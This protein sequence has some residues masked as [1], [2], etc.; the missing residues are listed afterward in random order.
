MEATIHHLDLVTDL[1]DA[2]G[3]TAEGLHEVR[4][5]LDGLLGRQAPAEWPDE[6]Y[7]RVA[8]GRAEPTAEERALL[9]DRLPV[10]S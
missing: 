10:F 4:R 5:V 2:T 6:R 9:G 8:T 7:A 3:P 1:P